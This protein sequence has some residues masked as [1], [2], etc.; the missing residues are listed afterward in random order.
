MKQIKKTR[1]DNLL[2]TRGHENWMHEGRRDLR[3][4]NNQFYKLD[5]NGKLDWREWKHSCKMEYSY[6][7]LWPVHFIKIKYLGSGLFIMQ[8]DVASMQHH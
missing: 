2:D 1:G 7:F 3:I 8:E 6:Q 4:K 5:T